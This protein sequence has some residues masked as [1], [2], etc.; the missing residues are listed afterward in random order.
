MV[1]IWF[2][3]GFGKA[4]KRLKT[5]YCVILL[6][7]SYNSF[8]HDIFRFW[9]NPLYWKA[10]FTVGWNVIVQCFGLYTL[11]TLS[12]FFSSYTL[13]VK[14]LY[15]LCFLWQGGYRG[16]CNLGARYSCVPGFLSS[17]SIFQACA[18]CFCF[19]KRHIVVTSLHESIKESTFGT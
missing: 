14:W 6:H 17:V 3:S 9:K 5:G 1:G 19:V 18:T 12:T 16:L 15:D 8:A 7:F 11:L 10:I 4:K 13:W 2:W